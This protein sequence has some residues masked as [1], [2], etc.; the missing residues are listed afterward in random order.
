MA[1]EDIL[2]RLF[3]TNSSARR[4]AELI[5]DGTP[6]SR[7]ELADLAHV[8]PTT[9]P[10]VVRMLEADGV[11][12]TKN[13]GDNGRTVIY[14]TTPTDRPEPARPKPPASAPSPSLNLDHRITSLW[15]NGTTLEIETPAGH[16]TIET[17]ADGGL[18]IKTANREIHVY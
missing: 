11:R 4:V 10:R 6:H 8:S 15:T 7:Q 3:R 13:V 1:R 12:I 16:Y 5:L 2:D 14:S 17:Q 9:I 18:L